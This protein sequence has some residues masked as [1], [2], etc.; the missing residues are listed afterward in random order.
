ML[1]I[2]NNTILKR[3]VSTVILLIQLSLLY[4]QCSSMHTHTLY[5]GVLIIH[6]HLYQKDSDPPGKK[7]SSSHSHSKG[8]LVFLDQLMH[9]VF[10]LLTFLA[11]LL[12]FDR[13]NIFY[14][15]FFE[16]V[17]SR[18]FIKFTS[19]RAPPALFY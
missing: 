9:P 13:K 15:S 19:L 16:N 10:L 17:K 18:N 11:I 1:S 7:N 6:S 5:N 4:I 12:L 14:Y 2:F 8:E 3:F